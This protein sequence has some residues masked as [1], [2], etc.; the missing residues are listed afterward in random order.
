MAC[1]QITTYTLLVDNARKGYQAITLNSMT[2]LLAPVISAGSVLE[3][4]GSLYLWGADETPA[5]PGGGWTNSTQYFIYVNA[6]NVPSPSYY[7]TTQPV[8]DTAKQGYYLSGTSQ[9]CIGGY[10]R[11]MSGNYGSK[12]NFSLVSNGWVTAVG[13]LR[14]NN[15]TSDPTSPVTGEIW[16]RS[17]L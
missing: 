4:N 17:D 16:F 12:F 9:R 11:D 2:D 1:S 14:L 6:V 5:A 3:I 8:W 10:Y 15:R 13:N 7:S